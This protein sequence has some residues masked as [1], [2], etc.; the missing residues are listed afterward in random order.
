[1]SAGPARPVGV[2]R[3]TP[4]RPNIGPP[5]AASIQGSTGA[6]PRSPLNTADALAFG[7]VDHGLLSEHA[8]ATIRNEES[9]NWNK[10]VRRLDREGARCY[11][12]LKA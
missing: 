11:T 9:L 2:S 12:C 1:M 6:E 4:T 3:E 8:T 5:G 7:P 10:C